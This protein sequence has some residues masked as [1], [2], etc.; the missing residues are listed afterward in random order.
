M[1]SSQPDGVLGRVNVTFIGGGNPDATRG[2]THLLHV[3]HLLLPPNRFCAPAAAPG[4]TTRT[5]QSTQLPCATVSGVE[6][7]CGSETSD[8]EG[9]SCTVPTADAAIDVTHS[10]L[11]SLWPEGH[12]IHEHDGATVTTP[13]GTPTAAAAA[14]PPRATIVPPAAPLRRWVHVI[15]GRCFVSGSGWCICIGTLR[16]NEAHLRHI[17]VFENPMILSDTAACS[18]HDRLAPWSIVVLGSAA[19]HVEGKVGLTVELQLL[20]LLADARTEEGSSS[21]SPS[22][23]G[24]SSRP[25]G[26]ITRSNSS[27]GTTKVPGAAFQRVSVSLH[28]AIGKS[29]WWAV[30]S[31]LE[32][33][34]STVSQRAVIPFER[35]VRFDSTLSL[36]WPVREVGIHAFDPRTGQV[37]L[38]VGDGHEKLVLAAVNGVPSA[39][40]AAGDENTDSFAVVDVTNVISRLVT[41]VSLGNGTDLLITLT[42]LH[43]CPPVWIRRR[44][45]IHVLD[46][47]T[48]LR[49]TFGVI[50]AVVLDVTVSPVMPPFTGGSSSMSFP[51]HGGHSDEHSESATGAAGTPP[52]WHPASTSISWTPGVGGG[53]SDT[54]GTP[55]VYAGRP[56]SGHPATLSDPCYQEQEGGARNSGEEGRDSANRRRQPAHDDRASPPG[57]LRR[58]D[59][60]SHSVLSTPSAT[61]GATRQVVVILLEGTVA[62]A[63]PDGGGLLNAVSR[64]WRRRHESVAAAPPS[65]VPMSKK[66]LLVHVITA[67]QQTHCSSTQAVECDDQSATVL[68]SCTGRE[69]SGSHGVQWVA[70]LP[71]N[72]GA[73]LKEHRGELHVPTPVAAGHSG[74]VP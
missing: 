24:A 10:Y 73:R 70:R 3:H 66:I 65:R 39:D 60:T 64:S 32:R 72:G 33:M 7:N 31:I 28:I 44:T 34:A 49:T 37:I 35:S 25:A 9:R 63:A 6:T 51:L 40:N 36:R 15:V 59:A 1:R 42:P 16:D 74:A 26:T 5:S 23:T 56:R 54:T 13:P 2:A 53:R 21:S 68:L 38:A 50:N 4:T 18:D 12:R 57:V 43:N 46:V 62:P 11:E 27:T 45:A 19:R 47:S 30:S 14:D 52:V 71:V 69:C 58:D 41:F 48:L 17:I 20:V 8:P 22:S 29:G 67:N 61:G 55:P